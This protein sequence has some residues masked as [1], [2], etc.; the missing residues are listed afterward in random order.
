MNPADSREATPS[1]G[2][3]ALI[4]GLPLTDFLQTGVVAF[5]AAPIL[6]DISA[7]PEEYSLVATL[8]AV[9]AIGMIFNHRWLVERLGWRTLMVGC[10]ALFAAGALGCARSNSLTGFAGSRMLMAMGASSFF[11]A[12]RV[13]VNQI[14][15]SPRRFVA[16]RF[17]SS[18]VAWGAVLGPLVA[19]LAYSHGSWRL[20]FD[21]LLVPAAVLCALTWRVLPSGRE[22]GTSRPRI[23]PL[24]ALLG[25]SFL[26]LYG[27]Q[28]A[29]FAFF[30]ESTA[31][32]LSALLALLMLALAIW[33]SLRQPTPTLAFGKLAQ[34]RYLTGLSIFLICYGVLGANN[35][36]VPVLLR[37]LQ[38]P[39]E[40]VD[41]T[42]AWGALGGVA[43]WIV[44]ARLLPRSQGPSRYYFLAFSLLGLGG[45]LTSRLSESAHPV[46]DVL[47]GLLANGAFII[48]ALSTT[49]LQTFQTLQYDDA[50]LSNANQVKNMLAQIGIAMGVTAATLCLQWR[51]ALHQT[52]LAE[53]TAATNPALRQTLDALS[54]SFASAGDP[55]TT[56][57]LSLAQ[58]GSTLTQ[59][60]TFLATLDYFWALTRFSLVVLG[61][62]LLEHVIHKWWSSMTA[63]VEAPAAR[64]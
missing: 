32:A 60:A 48:C 35:T 52:H 27:L 40:T 51:G 55:A 7:S 37:G 47:P 43:A 41:R 50:V 64:G 44:M 42:I 46:Y 5:N 23:L 36:M 62:V 39:L 13:L 33:L 10:C 24:L 20:A 31:L 22:E 1:A 11:T 59:E 58:L 56:A 53:S 30:A 19:S 28:R 34:A 4:C 21:A 9:V 38:L 6:G 54:S 61:L 16:I 18:G 45:L 29:N 63:I 26:L 25:G 57:R 14:P 3:F 15:P 8:Y 12:S 49:A 2:L 17:L